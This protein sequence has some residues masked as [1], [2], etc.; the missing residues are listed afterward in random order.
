MRLRNQ[1]ILINGRTTRLGRAM[2]GQG[3][4]W[5]QFSVCGRNPV[6]T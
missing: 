3:R 1:V 6:K 5:V 4:A 2:A